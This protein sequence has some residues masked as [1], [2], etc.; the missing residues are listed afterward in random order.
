LISF[1]CLQC[2]HTY[3]Y[4]ERHWHQ[5]HQHKVLG[6]PFPYMH[7]KTLCTRGMLYVRY[8]TLAS[9]EW[10]SKDLKLPCYMFPGLK[11]HTYFHTKEKN[12]YDQFASH[13]ILVTGLV[14]CQLKS[15]ASSENK[16]A[17]WLLGAS[18]SPSRVHKAMFA[19]QSINRGA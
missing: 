15:G 6:M 17:K 5:R 7:K 14:W 9:S 3:I 2:H 10:F 19:S 4:M 11:G 13:T 8:C 18:L 12:I 1:R 16:Q